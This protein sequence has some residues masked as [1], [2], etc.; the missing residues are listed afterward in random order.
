LVR[1][2]QCNRYRVMEQHDH[3]AV[4]RLQGGG[5]K[6]KGQGTAR[7]V[8][9]APGGGDGVMHGGVQTKLKSAAQKGQILSGLG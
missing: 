3:D 1:A 4:A 8:G 7:D 2:F 6:N 9:G 5:C